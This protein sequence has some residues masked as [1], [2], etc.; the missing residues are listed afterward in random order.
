MS[1]HILIID[2]DVQLASMLREY[3]ESREFKVSVR[4]SGKEGIKALQ[5]TQAIRVDAV[6]LD[7][8]LPDM[9]GFEICVAIR[10][11]SSVPIVMLTARG[12]ETDR[13][14]G[15]EIGAD[16]Y[17]PKPFNPRE[18]VARLN[19]V[20]R[21]RRFDSEPERLMIF[22]DLVINPTARKASLAGTELVLTGY[23]FDL[24]HSLATNAGRVISREALMDA[25]NDQA[26]D[27]SDAFDRSIDVH[28]SRIR[29]VIEK[30]PKVPKRILTVRGIGYVF[31]K[32][33]HEA[34]NS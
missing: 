6:I 15:L 9:D 4:H 7:L 23:Q 31:S 17:L 20:F 25:L 33:Q 19:A 5:A 14:I 8:M 10:T 32:L 21:R 11:E 3:L 28:I 22:G 2:D 13:I 18:L 26:P 34:D 27:V 29:A 12:E 1:E 16:D 30:D 24:L